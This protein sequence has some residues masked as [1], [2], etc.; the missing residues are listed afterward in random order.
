MLLVHGCKHIHCPLSKCMHAAAMHAAT[1][2]TAQQPCMMPA[3]T[4]L[5][6]VAAQGLNWLAGHCSKHKCAARPASHRV[7]LLQCCA[8]CC[9]LLLLQ[10]CAVMLQAAVAAMLCHNAVL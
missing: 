4:Y 1:M 6:Q 9:R 3:H 7:L 5:L 8:E 10:C 2:H